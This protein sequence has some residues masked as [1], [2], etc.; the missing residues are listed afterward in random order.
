MCTCSLPPPPPPP[1]PL[2]SWGV[3]AGSSLPSTLYGSY[4]GPSRST[5]KIQP[6]QARQ[7][8]DT[9]AGVKSL[10]LPTR[11]FCRSRLVSL[12]LSLSHL[13]SFIFLYH[14]IPLSRY[15]F[16]PFSKVSV[17]VH[18]LYQVTRGLFQNRSQDLWLM[19]NSNTPPPGELTKATRCKCTLR[20]KVTK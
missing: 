15:A 1:P 17:L 14:F 13:P 3:G 4:M 11:L 8:E 19:L 2:S 9:C 5:E 18:F 7:L 6:S 12:S 10:F 20:F 16:G